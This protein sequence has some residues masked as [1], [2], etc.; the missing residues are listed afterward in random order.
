MT[1]DQRPG[2]SEPPGRPGAAEDGFGVWTEAYTRWSRRCFSL[3][4]AVT[5]DRQLAEDAV[6][7]VYRAWS[8]RRAGTEGEQS[9]L[10]RWMMATTHRYAVAA[11]RAGRPHG[12]PDRA[13]AFAV[14]HRFQEPSHGHAEPGARRT[15]VSAAIATLAIVQQQVVVLAY[16]GGYTHEQIAYLT[17]LPV[18]T[19]RAQT[20][21]AVRLLRKALTG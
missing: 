21:C 13:E 2:G 4:F 18:A 9:D 1:A 20:V 11:A 8:L 17:E 7:E 14:L 16:L 15:V 3:A 10:D 6:I 19:V 12:S 5:R